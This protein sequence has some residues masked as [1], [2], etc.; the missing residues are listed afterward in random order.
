MMRHK[1][2]A[3]QPSIKTTNIAEKDLRGLSDT[4]PGSSLDNTNWD[5]YGTLLRATTCTGDSEAHLQ[6][7]KNCQGQYN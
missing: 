1:A 6:Y 4:A 2:K 5:G 7:L 3:Q